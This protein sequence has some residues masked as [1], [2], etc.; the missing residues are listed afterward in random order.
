MESQLYKP[1]HQITA[2]TITRAA[3]Y[4]KLINHRLH[5]IR[6]DNSAAQTNHVRNQG[7]RDGAVTYT[8][9]SE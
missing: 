1:V 9:S 5:P 2:G 4:R 6:L 8:C 7:V 3:V